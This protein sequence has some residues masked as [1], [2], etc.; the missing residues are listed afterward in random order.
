MKEDIPPWAQRKL[1][2]ITDPSLRALCRELFLNLPPEERLKEGKYQ[3]GVEAYEKGYRLNRSM[4]EKAQKGEYG[5]MAKSVA[6]EFFQA[7]GGRRVRGR[8][9]W[10]LK[11]DISECWDG[12][13][14]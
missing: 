5:I 7:H 14:R 3:D 11:Q 13:R 2:N 9:Y 4:A 12:D 6:D 1:D 8:A 10:Q